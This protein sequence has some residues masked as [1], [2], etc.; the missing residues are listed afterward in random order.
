MA[1]PM[2]ALI[3]DLLLKSISDMGE[4]VL[5]LDFPRFVFTNEAFQ[6]L[7]GYS[8][9]QLLDQ[10]TF[11]NLVSRND[12]VRVQELLER[13]RANQEPVEHMEFHLQKMHGH[14]TLVEAV[15]SRWPEE[16]PARV[17]A[18]VREIA[19]KHSIP[20]SDKSFQFL[21]EKSPNPMLVYDLASR[22]ILAV[23]DAIMG[24]YGYSESEFKMLNLLDLVAPSEV[25]RVNRNLDFVSENNAEYF[26][27][28]TPIHHHRKDG[29]IME[30][31]AVCQTIEY[32][33]LPA[34]LLIIQDMT[35]DRRFER[36]L[37]DSHQRLRAVFESGIQGIYLFDLNG[38]I[39]EMNPKAKK[40]GKLILDKELRVG[41]S[42]EA[43]MPEITRV[44]FHED[45]LKAAAGESLRVEFDAKMND[46]TMEWYEGLFNPV[47][48]KDGRI[49][50]VCMSLLTVSARKNAE[51]QSRQNEE[52]FRRLFDNANDAIYLYELNEDGTPGKY[53][54]VN[55]VAC[56]RMGYSRD[57]FLDMIPLDILE[58]KQRKDMGN[59]WKK[60]AAQSHM[61][62]ERVH[63]THAGV[64][65]PVEVSAHMFQWNGRRV[66]LSIARDLTER[67]RAEEIIRRQAYYDPLTNLPNRTLFKDRLEQA[68]AHAKRSQQT[69][70]VM[71]LDLDRFKTINETLGH[72]LGD[73]LLIG[74]AE[75][76]LEQSSEGATLARLTGDEF[77]FLIPQVENTDEVY[78]HAARVIQSLKEPFRL[79]TQDVHTSCGLGIVMYPGDGEDAETLLRNAETAMYRAKEQGRNNYQLYTAVMNAKAFKQLL[80]ENSMRRALE[81]NEFIVHYQPQVDLETRRV[82][83]AEALVR[84]QHP[85]L[86][87]VFPTEFIGL[88]EDTGLIVPLGEW[89]LKESCRQNKAWQAKG[90]PPITVAVNLSG[91][92]FL[93]KGLATCVAEILKET[94]LDAQWLGL[95]ITESVA[96]KDAD[97]TLASLRD[98]RSMG[99]R[100]ALDDFGTGYSSLSYLKRFPIQT[101]KIDQSFVRD[102]ATDPND[103][104]IAAAV[105]ALARSLKLTVV[106]EGVETEDQLE[107]LRAQGC[108]YVQGYLM[109]HPLPN[110]EFERF[111]AQPHVTW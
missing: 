28:P 79:G 40:I 41:D 16:G 20:K 73:R 38:R 15:F 3:D 10:A 62:F 90:L 108:R 67:K 14:T 13:F 57:E 89:V 101:I 94:G 110:D 11:F 102:L 50:G 19:K 24:L 39:L 45:F 36:G 59:I 71:L 86:G 21:F 64:R 66:V 5:V 12:L 22:S 88:A 43:V 93:Q 78:Q 18:L 83:G 109:S 100:L 33:G 68:M 92:Q 55:E 74:V 31:A 106:A 4:G 87:L 84:W 35:S 96:L 37:T 52:K 53:L 8:N 95:E 56:R 46:G 23:N 51:D 97:Y 63:V 81:R 76:L 58:P 98:F 42:L 47:K 80:M 65:L 17:I 60:L 9:Q 2:K 82:V 26:C 69:L 104:A 105:M 85:D 6:K 30:V 32:T 99:L 25:E 72:N 27:D 77:I 48:E 34:R 111:L 61:T 107:F 91:R 70:G 103:A 75:R 49:S 7:S 1:F 29:T 44:R 54:E